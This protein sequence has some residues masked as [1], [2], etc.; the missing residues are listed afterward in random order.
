MAAACGECKAFDFTKGKCSWGIKE[1]KDQWSKH[2]KW[3][4]LFTE[5]N[6]YMPLLDCPEDALPEWARSNQTTLFN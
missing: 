2:A 3:C 6:G 1:C 4:P 5:Q